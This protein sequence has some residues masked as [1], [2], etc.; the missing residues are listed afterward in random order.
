MT[1]CPG[2][3]LEIICLVLVKERREGTPMQLDRIGRLSSRSWHASVPF[4]YLLGFFVVS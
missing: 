1:W 4:L 3:V 2:A